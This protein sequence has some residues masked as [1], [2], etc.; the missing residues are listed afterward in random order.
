MSMQ[1]IKAILLGVLIICVY[2]ILRDKRRVYDTSRPMQGSS[3]TV[4]T[5]NTSTAMP[6]PI[7]V[8]VGTRIEYYNKVINAIIHANHDKN[9]IV[10]LYGE[11]L[12]TRN[13]WDFPENSNMVRFEMLDN[14]VPAIHDKPM[15][16]KHIWYAAMH[17]VWESPLLKSYHGDVVFM[18]DDVI[19]SPDFFVA[20]NFACQCKSKSSIIQVI[21]MGGWG[22]ENQI[23]AEPNTFTMKVSSSF[24]TM[25]YAFNRALWKEI[26]ALERT[27]LSDWVKTDWAESVAEALC[28]QAIASHFP[29]ELISFHRCNHVHIIQPTLSRVWHIGVLSQVGSQHESNAYKWPSSPSW[30]LVNTLM[31]KPSDGVLLTGMHD[32][33]GFRNNEWKNQLD[34]SSVK[35]PLQYR[36]R[37]WKKNEQ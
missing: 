35:F 37:L 31:Q 3:L 2:N 33:F 11:N 12:S 4:S 25:G 6:I 5:R 32:V 16:L 18:E 22:G 8:L 26:A 24:P 7:M 30:E 29:I 10:F 28:N 27:V 13:T 17:S 36:H 15:R 19:P 34:S 21:A 23:N 20:L 14:Q 1:S 9:R